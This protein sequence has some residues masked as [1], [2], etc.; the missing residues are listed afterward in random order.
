MTSL[1]RRIMIPV[2]GGVVITAVV[3]LLGWEEPLIV[4]FV[5]CS[6]FSLAANLQ[7]GYEIYIGNPKFAGGALAHIG[8]AIM[9]IGFVTSERYDEKKTV[10]LEKGKTVN[11]LG[12]DLTY[13][14]YRPVDGGKFGFVV[15]VMREGRMRE[16]APVMYFSEFTQSVMRHPDLINYLDRDFYVAPLS[17]EEATDGAKQESLELLRGQE[18]KA[19][20]LTVTFTDFDFDAF[21]R[22]AML[23][24][25]DFE[26]RAR[27][28]VKEEGRKAR[29]LTLAMKQAGGG[30]MEFPPVEFTTAKGESYVFQLGRVMPDREDKTKSKIQLNVTVPPAAG[31]APKQESLLIEAS[32][33]PY[34]NLVWVGTVTLVLGFLIT[35]VRRVAEAR[36][37]APA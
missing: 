20:A 7:V 19:G 17:L 16:V 24:R 18:T 6:A 21:Q 35:I 1:L 15:Q 11:V 23:E 36:I 30:G 8:I 22:G 32:V 13:D 33:K 26:I 27:L 5:F 34:I 28:T 4:A 29:D 14:G 10:A 2:V 37:S 9:F 3:V 12:Y 31:T 25:K